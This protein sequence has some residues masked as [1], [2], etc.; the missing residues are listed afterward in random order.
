[1]IR[2][3]TDA[4]TDIAIVGAHCDDIAIGIGGTLLTLAERRP[5]LQV[6][7]LVLSG[8]GTE[9]ESEERDALEAFCPRANV[10][11]TVL[12][13]PDGLAPAH[14]SC[15]KDHLKDFRGACSPQV[16]FG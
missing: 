6:H 10:E 2:L 12:D 7:A 4:I 1:M 8:Q 9:R 15:I 3:S 13:I 11:L 14:W 16:V 5:G